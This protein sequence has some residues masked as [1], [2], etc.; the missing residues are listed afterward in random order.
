[1]CY[2]TTI[3]NDMQVVYPAVFNPNDQ[4]GFDV[5]FPDF[6]GCVTYGDTLEEAQKYAAEALQLWLEEIR[7]RQENLPLV[8]RRPFINEVAVQLAS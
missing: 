2:N 4:G 1:M 5:S 3:M 8:A 7:S 6:P